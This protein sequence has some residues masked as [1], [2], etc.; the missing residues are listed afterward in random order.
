M[1]ASS[2]TCSATNSISR[3]GSSDTASV[4]I[5]FVINIG[6]ENSTAPPNPRISCN[7][8]LVNFSTVGSALIHGVEHGLGVTLDFDVVPAPGD[9]AVRSNQVGRPGDPHVGPAVARLL[10][11]HA[12]LLGHFVIGVGQQRE[13]DVVFGRE[14]R[15][16]L[17]VENAHAQDGG[18]A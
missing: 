12:V 16:A 13:V 7:E 8:G 1:P 15:L 11:P 17:L 14:L 4:H 3:S 18:L 10:L 2:I 6:N 5:S 9:L